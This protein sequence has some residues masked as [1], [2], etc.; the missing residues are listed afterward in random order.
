MLSPHLAF[1]FP[2]S[3]LH[4]WIVDRIRFI[5][6][7][8]PSIGKCAPCLVSRSQLLSGYFSHPH[9]VISHSHDVMP[10]PHDIMSNTHDIMPSYSDVMP[11]PLARMVASIQQVTFWMLH[12]H[13]TPPGSHYLQSLLLSSPL[14]LWHSARRI[15]VYPLP[16]HIKSLQNYIHCLPPGTEKAAG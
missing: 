9:E 14:L 7:L 2:V 4:L 5:S 13:H 10:H 3:S 16:W 1:T 6:Q 15:L 12:C 8:I 11:A